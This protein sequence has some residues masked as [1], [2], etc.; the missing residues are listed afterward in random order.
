[1]TNEHTITIERDWSKAFRSRPGSAD[2]RVSC[3]CGWTY[4]GFAYGPKDG[5]E[6]GARHIRRARKSSG[7]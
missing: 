5:E 3:S 6:I 7:L 2:F 1:M 4:S